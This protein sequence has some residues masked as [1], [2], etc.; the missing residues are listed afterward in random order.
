MAQF[1]NQATLSY[2]NTVTNSNIAVGEILE[3]ISATKTAINATYGQNDTITYIISIINSGSSSF[4]N[5]TLTDNLGSY[6]FGTGTLTPLNYTEGTLRYYVNGVLQTSPTVN[7]NPDSITI[8]GINIPA[9]GNAILVY[10][11]STN[12][13]APLNVGGEITNTAT[14]SGMCITPVLV[15]ETVNAELGP[16]L[17]ITKSISPVP[18]AE[19]ETVTYTFLIQNTGNTPL[20]ATDDAVIT[21]L[22]DPI[23]TNL[24]VTFNGATW[25]EGTEYNYNQQTGFFETVEGQ[26]TVPAA[27]YTQ[28]PVTGV[29]SITPGTSTLIVTGTI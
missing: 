7:V 28:D 27:T 25:T 15:E 23:L 13:F 19:G 11:V 20:V 16:N 17:S 2:G 26:V 24:G 18:V 9:G 4:N 6:P 1:T 12:A 22:F 21:D 5:L 10:E 8:N 14:I 29:W 3:V